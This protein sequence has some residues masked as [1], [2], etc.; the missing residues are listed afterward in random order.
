MVNQ[1]GE[2]PSSSSP[3]CVETQTN[4]ST[5]KCNMACPLTCTYQC[6]ETAN[7]LMLGSYWAKVLPKW[8]QTHHSVWCHPR[9]LDPKP[10]AP[11][12]SP[13]F[14][15]DQTFHKPR[16]STR[17]AIIFIIGA[18]MFPIFYTVTHQQRN[19]FLSFMVKHGQISSKEPSEAPS[20]HLLPGRM[21]QY[22]WLSMGGQGGLV[23]QTKP[24]GDR[25][26]C[27]L[28]NSKT[29]KKQNNHKWHT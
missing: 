22:L 16:D 15:S 10:F 26:S 19:M 20:Y 24:K 3:F 28:Y 7:V 13:I 25:L 23:N 27:V 12:R 14:Q 6:M 4:K 2:T 11:G 5:C 8:I 9:S 21:G 18:M 1:K 29:L 17:L